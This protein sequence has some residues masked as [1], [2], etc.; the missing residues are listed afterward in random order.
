MGKADVFCF[1]G[2]Q[3]PYLAEGARY[4]RPVGLVMELR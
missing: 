2:Y 3:D 1:Y 4:H